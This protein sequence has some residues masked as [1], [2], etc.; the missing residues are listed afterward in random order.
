MSI[1]SGQQFWTQ[2]LSTSRGFQS[3]PSTTL[4]FGL[5]KVEK[6]DSIRVSWADGVQETF[7]GSQV[8]QTLILKRGSGKASTFSI[9]S[10]KESLLTDSL[11]WKH[12]EKANST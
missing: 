1:F 8:N 10:K 4:V 11:A 7:G 12:E 5:G 2:R 6:V 9:S 3:S